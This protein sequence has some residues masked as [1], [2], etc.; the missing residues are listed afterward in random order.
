MKKIDKLILKAYL[1][2]FFATLTVLQFV[3]LMQFLWKYIDDLVGKGLNTFVILELLYYANYSLIPLTLPLSVLLSAIMS[4]GNLSEHFELTALKS[5]GISFLRILRPLLVVSIIMSGVAFIFS[6][7]LIPWANLKHKTLLREI[8]RKKLEVNLVEGIFFTGIDQYSIRVNKKHDNGEDVEDVTIYKFGIKGNTTVVKAKKGKIKFTKNRKYLTI[9]LFDGYTYKEEFKQHGVPKE[10]FKHSR[11]YFKEQLF[12]FDMTP[13]QL[14]ETDESAYDG[15][16]KMMTL[17]Q[18][19]EYQVEVGTAVEDAYQNIDD[20]VKHT[21]DVYNLQQDSVE[22]KEIELKPWNEIIKKSKMTMAMNLAKSNVNSTINRLTAGYNRYDRKSKSFRKILI[23]KHKKFTLSYAVLVL[24]LVGAPLGSIIRKGGMGLPIVIS[25][26]F[27]LIYYM[28][29]VYGEKSV[30]KNQVNQ[31]FGMW[32]TNAVFT[33]FGILFMYQSAT[34]SPI[35]DR[36][37]Y[38]KKFKKWFKKTS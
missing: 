32:L 7:N 25:V 9:D 5:S 34:D 22:T 1:G 3:F 19:K 12:R 36:D 20:R 15:Y 21:I 31:Y 4:M 29:S 2:P 16:A 33:P 35:F 18:L 38:K 37:F 23:E 28:L 30:L 10:N 11:T 24:F 27:F 14:G 6:N 26:I 13:F 17:K 8:M